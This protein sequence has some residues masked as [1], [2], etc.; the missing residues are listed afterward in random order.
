MNARTKVSAKGQVVIPKD[1]RDRLGW[2]PGTTLEVTVSPGGSV[3]LRKP[4]PD[5]PLSFAEATAGVRAAAAY[6]GPSFSEQEWKD[7]L[8]KM[9]RSRPAP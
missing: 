1:V 7:S 6:H 2:A 9:F 8:D 4:G 5:K 3:D